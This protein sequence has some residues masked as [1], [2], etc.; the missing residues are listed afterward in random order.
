MLSADNV[1]ASQNKPARN[2]L[3]NAAQTPHDQALK[4]LE[5][6]STLLAMMNWS[7]MDS[8]LCQHVITFINM[9][10]DSPEG[11]HKGFPECLALR[12]RLVVALLDKGLMRVIADLQELVQESL[13]QVQSMALATRLLQCDASFCTALISITAKLFHLFC[14]KQHCILLLQ[15]T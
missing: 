3:D 9:A 15:S 10:L 13:F 2:S 1:N 8:D 6:C 11:P 12:H 5:H 7:H 14:Y 4:P